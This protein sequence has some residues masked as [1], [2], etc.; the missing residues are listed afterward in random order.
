MNFLSGFRNIYRMV[1]YTLE[2]A[3][4]VQKLWNLVAVRFAHA[5]AAYLYKIGTKAVLVLVHLFL[6]FPDGLGKL[7]VVF[8]YKLEG[9]LY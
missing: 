3:Y 6:G 2:V 1:A 5:L 9:F 8:K 7:F 4:H